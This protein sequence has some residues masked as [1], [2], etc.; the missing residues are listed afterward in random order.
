M[1][2][3]PDADPKMALMRRNPRT[4]RA[5]SPYTDFQ[6]L[7]RSGVAFCCVCAARLLHAKGPPLNRSNARGTGISLTSRLQPR[8]GGFSTIVATKWLPRFFETSI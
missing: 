3:R 7:G 6:G 5:R 4:N 2:L 1:E 8:T